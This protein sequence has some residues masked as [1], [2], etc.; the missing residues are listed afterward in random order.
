ML[1]TFV[2]AEGTK[3]QKTGNVYLYCGSA[4]G[5]QVVTRQAICGASAGAKP[6]KDTTRA[7]AEYPPFA[8]FSAVPVFPAIL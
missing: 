6:A 4:E 8:T 7:L 5:T 1:Y 3:V 2:P